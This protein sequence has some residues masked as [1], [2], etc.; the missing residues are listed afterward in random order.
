[1][2]WIPQVYAV[3]SHN[4]II[5]IQVLRPFSL[6]LEGLC[7]FLNFDRL[8][9][10]LHY[11]ISYWCIPAKGSLTAMSDRNFVTCLILSERKGLSTFI[12]GS[13]KTTLFAKFWMTLVISNSARRV[14]RV[15][16][17]TSRSIDSGETIAGQKKR[18]KMKDPTAE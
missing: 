15:S 18:R 6:L 1:M 10:N 2:G 13:L 3:D 12:C 9:A 16:G 17:L 7:C 8:G 11:F 14:S 4:G 5:S